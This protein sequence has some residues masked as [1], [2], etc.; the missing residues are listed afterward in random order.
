[1]PESTADVP[2]PNDDSLHLR[3]MQLLVECA[4]RFQSNIS[5]ARGRKSADAKGI[6]DV[7]MLAA[8]KGP[9][10]LRADGPDAKEAVAALVAL[11]SEE[12]Q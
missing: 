7:M 8:D 11:L 12:L 4:S 1:M 2:V 6:L 3:P 9:V 5:V 10:R